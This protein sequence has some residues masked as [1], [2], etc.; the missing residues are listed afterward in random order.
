MAVRHRIREVAESKGFSRTKLSRRAEIN[1]KTVNE[2]WSNPYRVIDTRVLDRIARAL[3]VPIG[4]LLVQEPDKE[5]E[6][7]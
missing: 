6:E 2:L 3:H 7:R 1:Y 4:D 5:E